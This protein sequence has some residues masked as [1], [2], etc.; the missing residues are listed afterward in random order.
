MWQA[1]NLFQHIIERV[2]FSS[3]L[4]PAVFKCCF[5]DI[6]SIMKSELE[7]FADDCTIFNC[8]YNTTNEA[9]HASCSKIYA[10]FNHVLLNEA[11]LYATNVSG[12]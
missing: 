8:I 3:I 6:H 2:P 9:V 5:N 11:N 7:M 12:I 10:A 4:D 1:I